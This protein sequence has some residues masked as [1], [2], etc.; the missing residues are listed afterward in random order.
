MTYKVYKVGEYYLAVVK[1]L[2]PRGVPFKR[3]KAVVINRTQ[4]R[5]H[6]SNRQLA[7][8]YKAKALAVKVLYMNVLYIRAQIFN[9]FF[10]LLARL[11]E[12]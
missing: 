8:A 7:L 6:V 4:G 2:A 5:H 9:G 11:E 12:G 1:P 3:N 10:G